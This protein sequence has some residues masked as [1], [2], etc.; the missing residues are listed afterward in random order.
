MI[1]LRAEIVLCGARPDIA[2]S[3]VRERMRLNGARHFAT[4]QEGVAALL[5]HD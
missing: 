1:V 2:A 3:I 4:M 5:R